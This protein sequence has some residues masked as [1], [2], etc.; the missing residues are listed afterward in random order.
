MKRFLE[1]KGVHL[2]I[3][4]YLMD[5]LSAMALGLFATLIIGLIVKTIGEYGKHIAGMGW[6]THLEPVGQLAMDLMGPGIAVA[7]AYGLK[8]P[9]LV[10]FGSLAAGQTAVMHGA[11][12]AGAFIAAIVAA[13]LGKLISGETRIDIIVTPLV[14]L[15]AGY[16]SAVIIAPPIAQLMR[17]IGGMITWATEQQP[18][19]MGIL[20]A[21]L[22]GLALT[23][24][25]SSL[26]IAIMLDLS[27]IAAGAATI[28][29]CAQMIGFAVSSFRENG[30]SGF[31]AQGIGTSM[32]Q[33]PNILKAPAI[34][35]PPTLAGAIL[36]PFATVW[37]QLTNNAAGAG[38][39]TSGFVGQIMTFQQMGFSV[40]ILLAVL[41]LHLLGPAII[42]FVISEWMRKRG[43]IKFGE[44]TL[45][46]FGTTENTEA[47]R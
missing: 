18:L 15:L 16:F 47:S 31:I 28:G 38:M 30:W 12:P 32:L 43:W 45:P 34:L 40:D 23:A 14:T 9:P 22:M 29:C 17:T 4:V 7:V 25:I 19:I 2:S 46:K 21:V 36:A 35:I 8:A 13:E 44:Q 1:K 33:V 39:G 27:G 37:L 5:G 24:P 42:S 3:K 41:F 26:A 6:L 20:V 11:G 10:L